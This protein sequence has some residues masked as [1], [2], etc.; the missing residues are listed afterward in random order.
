MHQMNMGLA[1]IG[2]VVIAVALLSGLIKRSPVSE[3]VLAVLAGLAVGPYG[4]DW[5]DLARWGDKN[6]ILEQAAHLTAAVGLMS[7]ALRIQRQSIRPLLRPVTLLLTA[8]MLGMWLICSALAGWLLGLPLWT[9]LLLG[10]IG[11]PTDPVVSS[12]IVSGPFAD[13]NLPLR[14]RDGLSLES[15]ANDGLAYLL[16]M[17]PVL[18]LQHAPDQAWSQWLF[19]ALLIGVVGACVIGLAIGFVAAHALRFA[20]HRR[21]VAQPSLLGFTIALSL[22]T[23]GAAKLLH[24]DAII[25]VFLAGLTFNLMTDARESARAE[26]IQEMAAKLLML[27][28]FVIFGVALPLADWGRLGWPLLALAV[29]VL[30][31]R[32]PPVVTALR[33]LWRGWFNREDSRFLGWF[34]PIGVA[35]MYYAAMARN[36]VHDP[37]LWQAASAL[38]F[39]SILA[40]GISASPLT[41]LYA[42]HPRPAPPHTAAL[43]DDVE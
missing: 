27:P 11:T 43:R 13:K 37:L 39:T 16:V 2:V 3:P 1:I 25:S 26:N 7:V 40:H 35:A 30:L 23:L 12:S 5:L 31:L 41:R 6:V 28:M 18:M 14:L 33:P 4:L 20:L 22:F 36:H 9:A 32:R 19:E 29:L 21:L 8:G 34:G 15:G 10:A 38:I 42:R 17:L 24:A